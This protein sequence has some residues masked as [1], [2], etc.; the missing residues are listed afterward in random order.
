MEKKF[1]FTKENIIASL[2]F[3]FFVV[4]PRMA[5]MMHVINYYSEVSMLYTVF[6]GIIVSVPLL[7]LMVFVFDKTGVWG[8]LGFCVL[9]DLISAFVIQEVDMKAGIETFIISLFVV[10]GVKV[11]PYISKVVFE[12]WIHQENRSMNDNESD[13]K[14]T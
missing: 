2:A 5:G 11:A 14:V 3:A 10:M 7:M 9:T 12:K 8:A 4:C 13:H 6:L 1:V